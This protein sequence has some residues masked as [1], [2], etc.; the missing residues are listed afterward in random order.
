[1]VQQLETLEYQNMHV[2]FGTVNDKDPCPNLNLLPKTKAVYY[3]AKP[4]IP[5]GH[6]ATLLAQLAE[7]QGLKGKAYGSVAAAL[8]EAKKEAKK[9]DLILIIGSIFVVAEVL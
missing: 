5:R 8:Q 6:D 1:M 4:D 7:E 3:F 2:V 9:N